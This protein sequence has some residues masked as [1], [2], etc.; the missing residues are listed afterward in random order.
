MKLNRTLKA[1]VTTALP[2]SA[3]FLLALLAV[4]PSAQAQ[5]GMPSKL[6][7]P[8]SWQ[9]SFGR[10]HLVRAAF[11]RDDDDDGL[12][13]VGMWRVVFMANT[14]NGASIT[15]MPIDDA[16]VVW[17]RDGTE[18]MNSFRPPQDGDFCMGVW[19]QTGRG[20]YYLNHYAWFA[21]QYPNATKNGIGDPVGPTHITEKV[22]LSEDGSHFTGSFTLDAYSTAGTAGPVVQR[23]T[24]SI[25]GTRITVATAPSQ[26]F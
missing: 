24:G 9:P 7:K 25:S 5:C 21:N 22:T 2:V 18:I 16:L 6:V 8:A 13:I 23:F 10:A 4:P 11:G 3:A 14:S 20:T 19:E 15:P 1:F 26:L 12:S 17:H